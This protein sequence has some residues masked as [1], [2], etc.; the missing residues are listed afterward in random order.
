MVAAR[1][2]P[3][4]SLRWRPPRSLGLERLAMV[5]FDIPDIRLFWTSDQRFLKQFKAGDLSTKWVGLAQR[6]AQRARRGHRARAGPQSAGGRC[7]GFERA[8]AD[9]RAGLTSR[10]VPPAQVQVLLQVSALLQGCGLLGV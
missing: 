8:R 2:R 4:P 3:W 10:S 5:L 6:A 9:Q 7:F 1:W